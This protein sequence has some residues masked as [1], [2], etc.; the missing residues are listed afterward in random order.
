MQR[1]SFRQNLCTCH[2]IIH[3]IHALDECCAF[4]SILGAGNGESQ[5][6]VPQPNLLTPCTKHT[7]L[8][9]RP[10]TTF[11]EYVVQGLVEACLVL[12][13]PIGKLKEQVKESAAKY[14][15]D[16]ND[17][18]SSAAAQ[19]IPVNGLN[20]RRIQRPTPRSS[21]IH[22]RHQPCRS[23]HRTSALLAKSGLKDLHEHLITRMQTG[24]QGNVSYLLLIY[25]VCSFH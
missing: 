10:N 2:W 20:Q 21:A 9:R 24:W 13:E 16:V 3:I 11:W 5:S 4:L 18:E 12:I 22:L 7:S 25:R 1:T 23:Q 15:E 19:I 17:L 14:K 8:S 6:L